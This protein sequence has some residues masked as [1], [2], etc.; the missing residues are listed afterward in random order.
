MLARLKTI[1]VFVG[2]KGR[3]GRRGE[4][5][6]KKRGGEDKT[7]EKQRESRQGC[8]KREAMR[9]QGGVA[10]LKSAEGSRKN[11]NAQNLDSNLSG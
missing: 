9:E 1:D 6:S 2:C 11:I 3:E 4:G 8:R 5:E 10:N 7:K